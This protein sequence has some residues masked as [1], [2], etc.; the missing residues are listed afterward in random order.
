MS[1]ENSTTQP[2]VLFVNKTCRQSCQLLLW[3]NNYT[4]QGRRLVSPIRVIDV[5][6][7]TCR[8]IVRRLR[9]IPC[10]V[11]HGDQIVGADHIKKKLQF[12]VAST[13]QHQQPKYYSRKSRRINEY[14]DHD[15]SFSNF[16]RGFCR[17]AVP[18]Q[19]TTIPNNSNVDTAKG[20]REEKV[21][22]LE[23]DLEALISDRNDIGKTIS[24]VG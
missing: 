4:K 15:E 23:Q 22:S 3:I 7:L 16:A 18:P 17:L 12:N 13:H 24:R 19:N 10:L 14:H 2:R 1:L 8:G 6:K 5:S 21:A 20:M 9:G 11:T